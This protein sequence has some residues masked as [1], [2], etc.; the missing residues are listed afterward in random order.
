MLSKARGKRP[1]VPGLK[2][3][4]GLWLNAGPTLVFVTVDHIRT[5]E[6]LGA[7]ACAHVKRQTAAAMTLNWRNTDTPRSTKP[8]NPAFP[9]SCGY[10]LINTCVS[11]ARMGQS[12]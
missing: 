6:T 5:C 11:L 2:I 1:L 4:T 8:L 3:E 9:I 12:L 7:C 10:Q